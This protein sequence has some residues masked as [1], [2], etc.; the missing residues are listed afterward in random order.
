MLAELMAKSHLI[1]AGLHLRHAK[2]QLTYDNSQKKKLA[3]TR[4]VFPSRLYTTII[5]LQKKEGDPGLAR[6]QFNK[7]TT[8][9][10]FYNCRVCI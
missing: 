7:E 8:S 2:V 5:C 4:S 10:G 9:V 1:Q 3:Y 6:G